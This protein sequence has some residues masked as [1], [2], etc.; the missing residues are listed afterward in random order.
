MMSTPD[1]GET[2]KFQELVPAVR[3]IPDKEETQKARSLSQLSVKCAGKVT[4]KWFALAIE[5][6]PKK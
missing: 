6:L 1:L 2:D 5:T 4:C 3:K